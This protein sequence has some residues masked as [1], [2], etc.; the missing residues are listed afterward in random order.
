MNKRF[1]GH[2]RG[3]FLT[4]LAIVLPAVLTL[5]VIKWVFGTIS[6]MTDLLLC[7]LPTRLTHEDAGR[8]PMHWY[9]SLAALLLAMFLVSGVGLVA[10]YYIGKRI[11]A[12]FDEMLLRVPLLNKIY[13]TFKQVN[14]A[15]STGKGSSFKT[16]VLVEFPSPGIRSVG[17]LTS[18][19]Q[20][21]SQL[22]T[23]EKLVCVFI[24]TTPNPTSGFLIMVPEDKITKLD[25]S[26]ADGLKYIISFGNIAPAVADKRS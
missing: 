26:V 2:W 4:G 10:R 22:K 23:D 12:W 6:S 7:F 14:E 18:E 8:G 9:W 24:P 20:N 1:W 17:F 5:A 19:S 15:F 16:V 11:L 3:N 25:M 21:E 13:G